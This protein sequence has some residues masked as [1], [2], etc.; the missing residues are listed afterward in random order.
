VLVG[1]DDAGLVAELRSFVDRLNQR[2]GSAKVF[3][4]VRRAPAEHAMRVA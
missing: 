3:L 2:D 1:E 4:R